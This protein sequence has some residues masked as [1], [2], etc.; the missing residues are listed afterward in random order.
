MKLTYRGA[1]YEYNNTPLEVR[2]SE[3]LN[4]RS[5]QNRHRTLQETHYPLMYRGNRYTTSEVVPALASSG[6]YAAQPLSYRGV[7][8]TRSQDGTIVSGVNE[9]QVVPATTA[10]VIR[11]VSRIHRDNLRRNLE[12]RL[13]AARERGDRVLVNLLEAESEALA[14]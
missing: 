14:L 12:R 3:I 4:S 1:S 5:T 11:E 9:P 7:R 13:Q 2:E 6:A 8:Y 10:A